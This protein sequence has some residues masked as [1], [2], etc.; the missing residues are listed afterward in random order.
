MNDADDPGDPGDPDLEDLATSLLAGLT[1][2]IPAQNFRLLGIEVE[3]G[4]ML[5]LDDAPLLAALQRRL[6]GVE[7]RMRRVEALMRCIDCGAHYP[8][9]EHPCPVCGSPAAELVHGQELQISR[10]WGESA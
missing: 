2:Q 4:A 8:P 5:E 9:D 10:A 1:A 7:I 3:I 6:P